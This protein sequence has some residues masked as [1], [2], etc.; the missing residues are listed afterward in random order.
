M[1]VGNTL[2]AIYNSFNP[3]QMEQ[4]FKGKTV[5][6]TGA[7]WGIGA[8]I[9]S[10]YAACGAKVIVSDT[11]RKGAKDTVAKI[12]NEKGDATYIKTNVSSLEACEKLIKSTIET[13]GSIDIACNNSAIF[14]EHFHLG[15]KELEA[16][17]LEINVTIEGLGNCMR[18]EI[19]AMQKQG[20][21]IIVNTSSIVGAIGLDSFNQY[22][23]AK[24]GMPSLTQHTS[25]D[26]QAGA[27]H[28]YTIAP[29][30]FNAAL[31]KTRIQ[32]EKEGRIRS[33]PIA[34]PGI[35][36]EVAGLILWLSSNETHHL[37]PVFNDK[38]N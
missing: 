20:G 10:L 8:A 23:V 32:I 26:Y 30:F 9:A 4:Y 19:K 15:N 11:N 22:L 29:A 2:S 3:G 17:D 21:G 5:L 6:V 18:S 38:N 33:S 36:Q 35:V 13:Y 37:P 12:R 24:Y 7:G 16:F 31:L 34:T 1:F 25:G 28:I 27:I 14:S